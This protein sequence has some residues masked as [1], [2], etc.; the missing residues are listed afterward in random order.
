ML[1]YNERDV[2]ELEKV[3]YKMRHYDSSHPNMS[4]FFEDPTE[5]CTV[6]GSKD[7][8]KLDKKVYTIANAYDSY[9]CNCCSHIMRDRFTT[10]KNGVK[11]TN[12]NN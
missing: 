5:R 6:C 8:E 12:S 11:L 9:R 1:D 4:L 3:Y 7:V 2:I 10:A